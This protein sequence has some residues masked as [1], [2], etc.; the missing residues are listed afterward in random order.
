MSTAPIW[1]KG[2]YGS[3]NLGEELPGSTRG[4]KRLFSKLPILFRPFKNGKGSWYLARKKSRI[5]WAIS[6]ATT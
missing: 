2:L 4:R 5:A 1:S 3:K 6:L